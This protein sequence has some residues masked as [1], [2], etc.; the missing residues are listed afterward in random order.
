MVLWRLVIDEGDVYWN[1]A[2]DEAMLYLRENGFIPNTLRLYVIR[3]SAVTFGYFQRVRDAVNIGYLEAHNIQYT[4]RITGGG[5]VYHDMDGEITYSVVADID[6]ISWDIIESYRIICQ[7]IVYAIREFGLNAEYRPINDIIVNGRKISGSAQARKRR[8]L[9]QHGTL[10][11]NTDLSIIVKVIR[12]PREKLE[13]H[14]IRSIEERV[15]TL[16]REL[17]YNPGYRRV[18]DALV[19]GFRKALGVNFRVEKLS[20]MEIEYASRLVEKY[21][22]RQWIFKR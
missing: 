9:L 10:M 8:S 18:L 1:M 22:S 5:T 16:S 17:G 19:N 4:R 15:T 11:Y 14:G 13:S 3:P 6:D 7:G 20:P 2:V 21:R 12:V